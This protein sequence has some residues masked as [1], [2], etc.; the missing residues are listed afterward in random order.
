MVARHK[1]I[2]NAVIVNLRLPES[3]VQRIEAVGTDL[4]KQGLTLTRSGLVR[5]L[6]EQGLQAR[7]GK[8][9]ADD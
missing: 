6:L 1:E 3:L 2:E 4:A 9:K 8:G 7:E 5:F